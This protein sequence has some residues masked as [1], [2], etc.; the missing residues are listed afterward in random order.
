MSLKNKILVVEDEIVIGMYIKELLESYDYEVPAIVR[1][2]EDAI[3][4]AKELEPD[5]VIMDIQLKGE[6]DG[7]EASKQIRNFLKIPIVFLTGNSDS[8]TIQKTAETNPASILIKPVREEDLFTSIS[9]A[10][11]KQELKRRFYWNEINYRTVFDNMKD[12]V[13]VYQA[14]NGGEDFIFVSFNKAGEKIE[15]I[16]Q[17]DIIGKSVLKIFPGVKEFGLFDVFK[18]VYKTGKPETHPI[19]SYRDNRISG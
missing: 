17:E 5:L 7:I 6:I 10:L 1:S 13:A 4:K 16:K 18:R 12:G 19:T 14:V 15:G 11:Y 8:I 2:G 3:L 9:S